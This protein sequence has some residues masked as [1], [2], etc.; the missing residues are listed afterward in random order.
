MTNTL[1]SRLGSRTSS[2]R[3]RA[4]ENVTARELLTFFQGFELASPGLTID[5]EIIPEDPVIVKITVTEDLA[6]SGPLPEF[7]AKVAFDVDWDRN[8]EY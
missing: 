7:A 8:D 6:Y 4:N 2:F 5:A 1:F 3:V